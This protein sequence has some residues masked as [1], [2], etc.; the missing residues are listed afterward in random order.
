M[1]NVSP[2]KVVVILASSQPHF[3]HGISLQFLLILLPFFHTDCCGWT[4][5]HPSPSFSILVRTSNIGQGSQRGLLKPISDITSLFKNDQRVP[6]MMT[7]RT[8]AK[9]FQPFPIWAH[10]PFLESSL[11]HFLWGILIL[12]LRH[13]HILYLWSRYLE[14]PSLLRQCFSNPLWNS[15][16]VTLFHRPWLKANPIWLVNKC[17]LRTY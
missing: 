13:L 17:L 15:W 6:A 11:Q 5:P 16:N 4:P 14:C 3:W 8:K 2:L 7:H 1:G 9:A 12:S 10:L